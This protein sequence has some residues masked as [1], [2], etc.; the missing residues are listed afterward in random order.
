MNSV[1]DDSI[2]PLFGRDDELLVTQ[3]NQPENKV[4]PLSPVHEHGVSPLV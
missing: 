1:T 2:L 3:E 4:C